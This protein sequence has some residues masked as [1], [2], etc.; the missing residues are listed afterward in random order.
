MRCPFCNFWDTQVKNSRPSED[1]YIIKR[2]RS[3][4]N[5]GAKFTTFERLEIKDIIVL[6][7]NGDK[8]LFDSMKLLKSLEI[9]ARKRPLSHDQLEGIVSNIIKKLEKFSEGEI[10]SKI[11]GQLSMSELAKVDKIA[12]VRYASVYQEFSDVSD[13]TKFINEMINLNDTK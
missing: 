2:R 11:I 9:A 13:F 1:G 5:C 7:R 12:C 4:H 10:S 3:C 6:K 8:K